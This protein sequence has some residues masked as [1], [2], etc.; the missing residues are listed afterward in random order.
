M[1][2]ATS[3][4]FSFDIQSPTTGESR[5]IIERS[6]VK[7]TRVGNRYVTDSKEF[8][9]FD[10][11]GRRYERISSVVVACVQSGERFHILGHADRIRKSA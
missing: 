9:L 7:S 3:K 11:K 4:T 2:R 6:Y 5:V 10:G 1:A 8:A